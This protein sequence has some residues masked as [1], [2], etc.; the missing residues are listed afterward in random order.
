M[1]FPFLN[2]SDSSFPCMIFFFKH[3]ASVACLK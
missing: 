3:F 2:E 1:V